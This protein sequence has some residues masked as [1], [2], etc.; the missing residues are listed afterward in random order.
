[1]NVPVALVCGALGLGVGALLPLAVRW[2]AAPDVVRIA[3]WLTVPGLGSLFAIVG[4]RVGASP[5]LP[6]FLYLAAAGLALAII[7]LAVHRLPDRLTLSSYPV[8]GALL[9]AASLASGDAWP[10]GRAA[11]GAGALFGAYYLVAVAVPGGMGFGD[12]KLAGVLGLVLGWA[13]WEPLLLGALLAFVYGGLCSLLLIAVRRANRKSR[14][15]FGPFMLAGAATAMLIGQ[16]DSA[17]YLAV[18]A[19]GR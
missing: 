19:L 15:P 7:D 3:R 14:V 11:I 10:L 9:G 5:A 13:G 2:A 17:Q 8:A 16:S 18:I 4:A 6:A 1:V 12:V